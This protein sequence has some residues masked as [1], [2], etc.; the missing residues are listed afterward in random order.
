MFQRFFAY[1]KA[2]AHASLISAIVIGLLVFAALAF[3]AGKFFAFFSLEGLL[4]VG[5][6][7]VAVAFMSYDAVDVHAALDGIRRLF[8]E[9]KNDDEILQSDMMAIIYCARLLR[10]KG[11]RNLESVI[12]K[13]GLND[14][15]VK[16]GF[17]MAVSEYSSNDVRMMMETAA[18]ASYERAAV[19]VEVLHAMAS[20]APAFGMIG[21]LVGMVAML[22]HLDGDMTTIG[23]SL[24]VSFLSTLYGVLS[25]RLLYM[26]AA[27][28]Y[29]Q[30]VDNERFRQHLITEG[31]AMLIDNRTPMYI[32]DRLNSFLRLDSQNYIDVLGAKMPVPPMRMASAA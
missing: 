3:G 31:M 22:S 25:A 21:T 29:Q 19:P 26:P 20:H 27:A 30:R 5:G 2:P 18:D 14:P 6:G 23:S 24:A 9:V 32:Q 13:S 12:A 28:K 4:I 15:F 10:E 16:Y 17:N 8:K 7:V 1:V 11:M